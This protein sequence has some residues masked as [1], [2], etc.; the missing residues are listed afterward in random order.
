[1]GLG[2]WLDGRMAKAN[3]LGVVY[4]APHGN[5]WVDLPVFSPTSNHWTTAWSGQVPVLDPGEGLELYARQLGQLDPQVVWRTQPAVRKVVGFIARNV[6]STSFKLYNRVSDD[7]RRTVG[8]GELAELLRKPAPR[9]TPYRLWYSVIADSCVY[10]RWAL[11]KVPDDSPA[12]MRLVRVPPRRFRFVGDGL[13]QLESI[14]ILTDRRDN[15]WIDYDPEEF[16]YDYGYQPDGVGGMSPMQTLSAVLAEASEAIAWRRQVWANGARMSGWIER[17][18]EKAGP[19]VEGWN[20][21]ARERFL[22]EFRAQFKGDGPEAGG[23]G[24]VDDGMSYHEAKAFSSTDMADLEYRRLTDVEVASAFHIAPESVGARET[25]YSNMRE[26]RH[27]LYRDDLGPH[28]A[29][30]KQAVN[31]QL[32]PGFAGRRK[33]YI[34]VDLDSKLRGSFEERAALTSTA[35]GAPWMTR[36]EARA[37]ENRPAIDGGDELITPLNVTLGTQPSPQ[38]PTGDGGDDNTEP[39]Q[40][41]PEPKGLQLKAAQLPE[42]TR[43][44][45]LFDYEAAVRQFAKRQAASVLS[46]LGAK[47]VPPLP[48]AWN[49]ERW[50]RELTIVLRQQLGRVA[51]LRATGVG[52]NLSVEPDLEGLQLLIAGRAAGI[53]HG[54]NSKT[55]AL[56]AAAVAAE[57]WKAEVTAIFAAAAAARAAQLAITTSTEISALAAVHTGSRPDAG[58]AFKR[59]TVRS[60]NP[61]ASHRAL[62]GQTVPIDAAFS[63]GAQYPG[64]GT[65]PTEERARCTCDVQ[66]LREDS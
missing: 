5:G 66:I 9:V 46:G 55:Y 2:T 44:L 6:A 26:I 57:D 40:A 39:A 52:E 29:T 16:V 3:Q 32:V 42:Q 15:P 4:P 47:S 38:T 28:F 56:L 63:N 41:P 18:P 51:E 23:I 22:A 48:D 25:N 12:G 27:R 50:D 62:S 31:A 11:W 33:W 53:A 30:I 59:W 34:D 54:W 65:L 60:S 61:R 8:T 13:D 19:N 1:M 10:D 37:Q 21:R 43:D 17:D 49:E 14:R 64:A 7:E 36:N 20:R 45:L 35:V 58:P 24:F